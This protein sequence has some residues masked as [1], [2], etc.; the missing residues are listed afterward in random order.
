MNGNQIANPQQLVLVNTTSGNFPSCTPLN[1]RATGIAVCGPTSSVGAT[2]PVN[3]SFAGSNESPGR[4]MEIWVDG[5]K[6]DESLTRNYS[7]Y[8][9]IQG[10]ISVSPGQHQ[11]DVYSVGWDYSLL[12]YSIPLIVGS[13]TCPIPDNGLNVCSPLYDSILPAGSPVLIYATGAVPSGTA[14]VRM[15]VW[16][17]GVK[18]YSTFGSH[19]LRTY[20]TLAPGVHHLTYYIVN[21]SGGLQSTI[22]TVWVQ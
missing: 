15:E 18:K 5:R 21:N 2:S 9:F 17:D 22:D 4:D 1:F 20:L 3:F 12:E 16:I 7:Y 14:L 11:V 6:L 8:D 13:S 19:T 10:S